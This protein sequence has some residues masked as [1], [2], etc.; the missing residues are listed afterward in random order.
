V[1]SHVDLGA[2]AV[3]FGLGD[4]AGIGEAARILVGVFLVAAAVMAI[5][6]L[7]ALRLGSGRSGTQVEAQVEAPAA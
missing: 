6:A 2:L 4:V 7:P 5:A 1:L 3:E